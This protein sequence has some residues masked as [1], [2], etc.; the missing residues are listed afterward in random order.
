M[1]DDNWPRHPSGRLMKM[2]EM[3]REQQIAATRRATRRLQAELNQP[4]VREQMAVALG[5]GGDAKVTANRDG[6]I[7]DGRMRA[8]ALRQIKGR[9]T[10]ECIV[11]TDGKPSWADTVME[12][13]VIDGY[14]IA[15]G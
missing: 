1:S 15:A 4:Q 2:G 14:L 8:D 10:A 12:F 11:W 6:K 5:V 9:I 3:T 13:S 7:I